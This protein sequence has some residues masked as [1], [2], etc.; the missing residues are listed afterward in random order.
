MKIKHAVRLGWTGPGRSGT[1]RGQH[2]RRTPM[3]TNTSR[4]KLLRLAGLALAAIPVIVISREAGA[5]TNAT[6]RAQL[7]Y[8]DTRKNDQDCAGC[9]DFIPGKTDKDPG[10]CKLIPGDDQISP[11]GYCSAWNTM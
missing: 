4:R 8:Q 11:K 5:A 1:L 3:D 9:L 6:L 2:R 7:K 10:G